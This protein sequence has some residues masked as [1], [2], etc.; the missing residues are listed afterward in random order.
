MYGADVVRLWAA[1]VDYSKDVVI[2]H[3]LLAQISDTL[4]KIRNTF[5]FLLANTN[6][7]AVLD[8]SLC[9]SKEDMT[10]VSVVEA[11]GYFL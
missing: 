10:I 6:E 8:H 9:V 1:S 4:R 7:G 2:G 3:K 5:R 11:L